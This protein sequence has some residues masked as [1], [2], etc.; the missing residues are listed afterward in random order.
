MAETGRKSHSPEQ[1]IAEVEFQTL[2]RQVSSQAQSFFFPLYGRPA[3]SVQIP[4]NIFVL[5]LQT[6]C[7]NP[8]PL[9]PHYHP[10]SQSLLT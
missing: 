7:T 4:S 8:S 1:L 10:D 5:V 9:L 3:L 6:G 2:E